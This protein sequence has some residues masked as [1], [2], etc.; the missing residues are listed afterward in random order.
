MQ[1]QIK[2][3]KPTAIALFSLIH[4]VRGN[5]ETLEP[6]KECKKHYQI[7]KREYPSCSAHE[8]QP[9][10][11]KNKITREQEKLL[12]ELPNNELSRSKNKHRLLKI[13]HIIANAVNNFTNFS[14][15]VQ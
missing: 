7:P 3:K 5:N 2:T 13:G 1:F 6:I 11:E 10:P 15:S 12:Q 4:R 9:T 14:G 8:Y